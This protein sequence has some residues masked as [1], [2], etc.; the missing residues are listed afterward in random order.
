M[1]LDL[2]NHTWRSSR[3]EDR[4]ENTTPEPIDNLVVNFDNS[5]VLSLLT[6]CTEEE[7][8]ESALAS[9]LNI[10]CSLAIKFELSKKES[11]E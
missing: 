4:K 7:K 1:I 3:L 6:C 11:L 8:T 10:C 9:K 5:K 2:I